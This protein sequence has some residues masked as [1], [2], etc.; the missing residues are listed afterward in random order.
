LALELLATKVESY[1][2]LTNQILFSVA[3][4]Y[5]LVFVHIL[6]GSQAEMIVMIGLGHIKSVAEN[7]S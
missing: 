1:A 4:R 7:L 6:M 5:C 2:D 3:F